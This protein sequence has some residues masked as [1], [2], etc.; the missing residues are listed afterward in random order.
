MRIGKLGWVV[1]K[2]NAQNNVIKYE[3]ILN[4]KHIEYYGIDKNGTEQG[5]QNRKHDKMTKS[6]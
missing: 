6:E 3:I 5:R 2:I 4:R 1:C